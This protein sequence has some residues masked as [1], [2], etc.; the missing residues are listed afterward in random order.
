MSWLKQRNQIGA[1]IL[2]AQ[3]SLFFLYKKSK[4][5]RQLQ[6]DNRTLSLNLQKLFD[7]HLWLESFNERDLSSFKTCLGHYFKG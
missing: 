3:D 6:D 7:V 1:G 4:F 5:P 2:L